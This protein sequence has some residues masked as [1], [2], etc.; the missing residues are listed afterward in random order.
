MLKNY[1]KA[2]ITA[3]WRLKWFSA[4]TLF[5]LAISLVVVTCGA[6][7][8]N[9]ITAPI[10]PEVNKERTFFLNIKVKSKSEGPKFSELDLSQEITKGFISQDVYQFKTPVLTTVYEKAGAITEFIRNNKTKRINLM[11]TDANFFKVFEFDFVAGKPYT[12][13]NS[14][15]EIIPLCV[16][17]EELANYYFGVT[18]CLGQI[19]ND[20]DLQYKVVG[21]IKK[22][23]TKTSVKSDIY[24]QSNPQEMDRGGIYMH[25]VAFLCHSKK[26]KQ[27]LDTELKKRIFNSDKGQVTM[28]L[29]STAI[30][31]LTQLIGFK[32]ELLP[33]YIVFIL[34]AL[35]I[36]ILCLID[37]LKNNQSRRIEELAIRRAFGAP[38]TNITVMLLVDNLFVTTVGGILGLVFSFLFFAALNEDSWSN[39][40]LVFFNWRA[41]F[42][43]IAVFLIIGAIAGVLPAYRLSKQQIVNALNG[44]E[45]D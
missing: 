25:N 44:I 16:V 12:Q 40:F 32:W 27:E 1:L 41:F 33:V 9:M 5:S 28:S 26:D 6:S 15:D 3:L 42:Y 4:L 43:Y 2:S 7:F 38:R 10:A 21:V 30:Q 11:R 13:T 45:N 20:K 22:P 24:Y 36:P 18:D 14:S 29:D 8:W 19:I 39:L 35:I 34:I 23:T 37:I 31:Y 17:S